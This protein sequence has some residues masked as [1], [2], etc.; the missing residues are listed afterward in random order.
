[1]DTVFVIGFIICNCNFLIALS[2][3]SISNLCIFF[4]I[5]FIN[6]QNKKLLKKLFLR[7][8][9]NKRF[10]KSKKLVF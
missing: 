1:M 3:R 10:E 5:F 6:L 4:M 8:L 7:D 2:A 9:F